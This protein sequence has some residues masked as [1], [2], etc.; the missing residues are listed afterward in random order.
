MC[1]TGPGITN[2]PHTPHLGRPLLCG[3]VF[4]NHA[5]GSKEEPSTQIYIDI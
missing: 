3:L 5:Y 1:R 2:K 4:R